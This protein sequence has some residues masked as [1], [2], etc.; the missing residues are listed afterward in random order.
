MKWTA[1]TKWFSNIPMI[2]WKV[3]KYS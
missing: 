2:F 1:V 3:L